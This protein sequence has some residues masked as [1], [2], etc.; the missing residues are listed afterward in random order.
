MQSVSSY[1]KDFTQ[2]GFWLL[3]KIFWLPAALPSPSYCQAL[4]KVCVFHPIWSHSRLPGLTGIN[5][6]LGCELQDLAGGCRAPHTLCLTHQYL[7]T[8]PAPRDSE[9]CLSPQPGLGTDWMRLI[10]FTSSDIQPLCPVCG[11]IG[12]VGI[13]ALPL[14]KRGSR[15]AASL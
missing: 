10:S 13:Q 5:S 6:P 2:A 11:A 8:V 3:D 9:S 4:P 12:G 7:A 14:Q 1:A 15:S